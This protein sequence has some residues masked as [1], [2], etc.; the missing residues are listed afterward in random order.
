MKK[1][2]L[3][4]SAGM[5]T[6]LIVSRTMEAVANQGKENEMTFDAMPV[7]E[8][9]DAIREAACVL[10]AP[11]VRFYMNELQETYPDQKFALIPPQVYGMCDGPAIIKLAETTIG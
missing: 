2:L 5:S 7:A 9:A 4:C 10:V 6:S 3:V 1:I 8:A 11:Q